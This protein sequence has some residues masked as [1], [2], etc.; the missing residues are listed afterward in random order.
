MPLSAGWNSSIV[1]SKVGGFQKITSDGQYQNIITKEIWIEEN[2]SWYTKE[3]FFVRIMN[4]YKNTY[5]PMWYGLTKLLKAS[6]TCISWKKEYH[7]GYTENKLNKSYQIMDYIG[8]NII[9]VYSWQAECS[10]PRH[11]Q[12]RLII[13]N[14]GFSLLPNFINGC[15]GSSHHRMLFMDWYWRKY[16]CLPTVHWDML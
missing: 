2:F 5:R 3:E 11:T 13:A 12:V 16:S 1:T 6:L 14:D 8:E 9:Q 7:T 15:Y 10:G 4:W